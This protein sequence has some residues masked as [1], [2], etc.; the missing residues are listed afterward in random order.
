M[1]LWWTILDENLVERSQQ[2]PNPWKLCAGDGSPLDDQQKEEQKQHK[3]NRNE[4]DAAT[5][6]LFMFF[7]SERLTHIL[8]FSGELLTSLDGARSYCGRR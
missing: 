3:P 4:V 6:D 1:K 8:G 7:F 5:V 2:D